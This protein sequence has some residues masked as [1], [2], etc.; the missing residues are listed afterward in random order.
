MVDLKKEE[1]ENLMKIEGEVRGVVFQTDYNYVL[2]K[3]GGEGSKKIEERL[4]SFGY[5][6]DYKN[7]K[8]MDW[9]PLGLRI[10][11]LL[12]IQSVFGW[13]ESEIRKMGETAPK[14]SFVVK[15]LFKLFSPLAKLVKEIPRYWKEHYTI[16][17]LGMVEF[18]EKNKKL[19]FC[20]KNFEIHPIFCLYLEGYFERVLR[21]VEVLT[22]TEETKCMFKGE[23]YH[24]YSFKWK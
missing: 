10:V 23:P 3:E 18:D 1:L 21:F 13:P 24:E 6:I 8:A 17:E 9:C 20:L 2:A 5:K 4:R 15:F 14:F 12:I 19:V 16:G 11:S 22:T 7:I